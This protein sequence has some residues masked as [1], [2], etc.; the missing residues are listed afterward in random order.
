MLLCF[1]LMVYVG[2]AISAK[3][4]KV[5]YLPQEPQ[6]DPEKTVKE[7]V[8]DGVEAKKA[9]LDQYEEVCYFRFC[10]FVF[11]FVLFAYENG[12]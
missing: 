3:G 4:V 8:L 1:V 9:I 7:N 10:C 6:L 11:V 2:E 5:G 12:R